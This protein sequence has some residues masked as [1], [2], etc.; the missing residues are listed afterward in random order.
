MKIP[1][2]YRI[3][4]IFSNFVALLTAEQNNCSFASTQIHRSVVKC[5]WGGGAVRSLR[6][7]QWD[8]D[9]RNRVL[10]HLKLLGSC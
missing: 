8:S 10:A 6:R 7:I 5:N 9:Y 2:I 3:K 1:H 4:I